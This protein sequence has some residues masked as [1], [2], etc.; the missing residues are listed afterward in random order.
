[1]I[2]TI[3]LGTYFAWIVVIL[4]LIFLIIIQIKNKKK[5]DK[6]QRPI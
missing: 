6:L 1:M 2:E 4:A 3:T 5:N